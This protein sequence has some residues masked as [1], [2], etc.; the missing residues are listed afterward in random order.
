[1]QKNQILLYLL[2]SL[3][4]FSQ[5]DSIRATLLKG[6]I[7]HAENQRA[8]SAAHILNLNTVQGTIHLVL[9]SCYFFSELI[10]FFRYS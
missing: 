4:A 1:M 10:K 7:I 8:L 5:Q 3:S 2:L 6:Q 9:F